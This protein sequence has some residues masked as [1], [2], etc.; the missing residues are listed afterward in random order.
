MDVD[1]LVERLRE[2]A[3]DID[4]DFEY[5]ADTCADAAAALI[6]LRAERDALREAARLTLQWFDSELTY[7]VDFYARMAMC[8]EAER[9]LRAALAPAEQPKPV[10]R[11]CGRF[12]DS[13]GKCRFE[14][15]NA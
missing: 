1:A 5:A 9:K 4:H 6:A 14:A 11:E 3:I 10:C 8:D 12:L 15:H 7:V 2:C 13:R